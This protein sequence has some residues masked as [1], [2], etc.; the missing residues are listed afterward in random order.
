MGNLNLIEEIKRIIAK[1]SF[2][3]FLWASGLT[4]EEYWDQIYQQEKQFKREGTE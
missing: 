2:N 4:D 3:L 1:F